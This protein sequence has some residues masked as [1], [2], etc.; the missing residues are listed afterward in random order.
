MHVLTYA[1]LTALAETGQLDALLGNVR[2]ILSDWQGHFGEPMSLAEGSLSDDERV[3]YVLAIVRKSQRETGDQ[4]MKKP[5]LQWSRERVL[6]RAPM[7][8]PL[9]V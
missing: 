3:T 7:Q 6:A 5:N 8:P 2:T 4:Y 1:A 9:V